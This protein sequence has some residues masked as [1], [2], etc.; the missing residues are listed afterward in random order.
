MSDALRH[1]HLDINRA[2]LLVIDVQEKILPLVLEP[3]RLV[4]A[5]VKM[6]DAAR[7][8]G[9]PVLATEQY[10]K[11]LGHT[12][13]AIRDAL[14]SCGSRVIEKPSFS[15][16]GERSMRDA[17][18][19]LSRNQVII[20]GIET[21]V[22]VQQT[23]LDLLAQNYTTFVCADAVSG[24]GALNHS[25]AIE[26]MRHAGAAVSTVESV[27]LELC[28]RTDIPVFKAILEIVK[29]TAPEDQ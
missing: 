18:I 5:I 4:P 7:V 29:R 8:L 20:V 26:R 9:I 19:A 17:L 28:G 6:I 24:R 1:D 13:P 14:H 23:A 2:M 12:V 11:G 10:P 15:A 21:H 27:M 22:C 16:W 3:Q 25:V